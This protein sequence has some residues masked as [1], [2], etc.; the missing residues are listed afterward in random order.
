MIEISINVKNEDGKPE[1]FIIAVDPMTLRLFNEL[2]NKEPYAHVLEIIHQSLDTSN[3]EVAI[4]I[5]EIIENA[6]NGLS[7][8]E[9]VKQLSNIMNKG[10]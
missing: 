1:G 4:K 7:E 6:V 2:H 3:N 8:E 10:D 5:K 9:V